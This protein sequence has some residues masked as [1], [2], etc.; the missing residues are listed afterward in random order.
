MGL[1]GVEAGGLGGKPASRLNGLLAGR[2]TIA[3]ASGM[4]GLLVGEKKI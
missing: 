3:L 1:A 4:N 2:W